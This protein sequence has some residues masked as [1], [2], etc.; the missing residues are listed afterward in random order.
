GAVLGEVRGLRLSTIASNN[1]SSI[2][3]NLIRSNEL[4]KTC[5]R[6]LLAS[7]GAND[8][9]GPWARREFARVAASKLHLV[10]STPMR[11]CAWTLLAVASVLARS[12]VTSRVDFCP[13]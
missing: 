6:R 5:S 7:C 9:M 11:H 3:N 8:P 10:K 13:T 2:R 12:F 4:H 1:Q